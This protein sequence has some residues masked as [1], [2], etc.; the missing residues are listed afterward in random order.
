M[1]AEPDHSDRFLPR[2]RQELDKLPLTEKQKTQVIPK[3]L[4]RMIFLDTHTGKRKRQDNLRDASGVFDFASKMRAVVEHFAADGLTTPEYLQAAVK[5]PVLFTMSPTTVAANITDMVRQFA[6]HDLTTGD[7]LR[8][9]LKQPQLFYQKPGTLAGNIRGLVEIF[10]VDGPTEK[11]FLRA[12][13]KQPQLFYQKPATIAAN[14]TG[15]AALFADRGLTTNDYL[16]AAIKTPHLF[17]R[18]PATVAANIMGVVGL[19]AVEG[20]TVHDYLQA[21][22]KRPSAISMTPATVVA[23]IRGL[24]ERFTAEGLTAEGYL[25]AALKNPALFTRSPAVIAGHITIILRLYDDGVFTLPH[26]KRRTPPAAVHPHPHAPV[27]AFL[28]KNPLF[29][30]LEDKNLLLRRYYKEITDAPPSARILTRPRGQ[31]E[32]ELMRHLGHDDPARPVPKDANPVLLGLIRDGYIK[33]AI[34]EG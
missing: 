6:Q 31:I 11:D 19:F 13:L 9:A 17:A 8:A 27:I 4:D 1:T 21:V 33:G 18:S 29:L 2:I 23:N 32:L 24:A 30:N 3:I 28:L 7:Y 20:L 14:I 10:A 16:W 25:R 26:P 22:V 15:V 12:A 34:I 5:L